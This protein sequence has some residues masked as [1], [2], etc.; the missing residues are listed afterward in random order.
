MKILNTNKYISEKLNVKPM[1]K[2]RMQ[3]ISN[4]AKDINVLR[5]KLENMSYAQLTQFMRSIG[6]FGENDFVEVFS[7]EHLTDTI[8]EAM[9]SGYAVNVHSLEKNRTKHIFVKCVKS[10]YINTCDIIGLE[11]NLIDSLP[12]QF[13]KI[14][15]DF[16]TAIAVINTISNVDEK[17]NIKPVTKDRLSDLSN[18]TAFQNKLYVEDLCD[19]TRKNVS[20]L[21]DAGYGMYNLWIS[22]SDLNIRKFDGMY[23]D[24]LFQIY[25]YE[26]SEYYGNIYLIG[27]TKPD[28]DEYRD[29]IVFKFNELNTIEKRKVRD[30]VRKAILSL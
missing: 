21:E 14:I 30:A 20:K 13:D 9:E 24:I 12:F 8:K 23:D 17:L 1:T 3:G 11:E 16:P 18:D 26:D 10:P 15:D 6:A 5:A 4:D 25:P 22:Q 2:T 7:Y 29:E 28:S 19:I 27:Y